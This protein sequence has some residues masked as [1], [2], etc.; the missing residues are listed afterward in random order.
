MSIADSA[1]AFERQQVAYPDVDKQRRLLRRSYARVSVFL[2]GRMLSVSLLSALVADEKTLLKDYGLNGNGRFKLDFRKYF[3]Q[4]GCFTKAIRQ[5][6][7]ISNFAFK[8][9]IAAKY[10]PFAQVTSAPLSS[11]LYDPSAVAECEELWFRKTNFGRNL[12]SFFWIYFM[13]ETILSALYI[14]SI[15][16]LFL[17]Y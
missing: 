16:I 3:Q 8:S 4:L 15:Y 5:E 13:R 17:F 11:V 9:Q 10:E 12:D 14:Y 2:V 6:Y 7:T 1:I